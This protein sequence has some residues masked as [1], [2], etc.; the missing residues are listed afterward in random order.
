MTHTTDRA[1]IVRAA[2][3]VGGGIVGASLGLGGYDRLPPNADGFG[4]M[5]AQGFFLAVAGG[6][7][8]IGAALGALIGRAIEA[9]LR[10]VGA[11]TSVTLSVATVVTVL[12]LVW[13]RDRVLAQYPGFRPATDATQRAESKRVVGIATDSSTRERASQTACAAP[14][15]TEARALRLWREECR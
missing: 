7:L 6:G 13:I 4:T 11:R 10:R 5:F 15:P 9:L 3:S 12:M 14:P 1:W 2:W 8:V